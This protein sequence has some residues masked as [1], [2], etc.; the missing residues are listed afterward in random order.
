MKIPDWFK[1]NKLTVNIDKT[2]FMSFGPKDDRV[3]NIEI[4]G[5][6]VN[7]SKHTK[8]L[9]LWIDEKLNWNKH[10][11]MLIT[12]LKRNQALIRTKKPLFNQRTLKLIYYA[13]IQNHI[14]YGLVIWGGMANK[15]LLNR[16]Q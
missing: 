13:H 3:S 8:F 16:I 5:V 2:V 10:C 12:K 4:G 15:E 14:N 9:G 6:K 1:A 7:H 11:S